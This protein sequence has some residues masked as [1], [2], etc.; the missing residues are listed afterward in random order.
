MLVPAKKVYHATL[1]F[2]SCEAK[3]TG[4]CKS[5]GMTTARVAITIHDGINGHRSIVNEASCDLHTIN[6]VLYYAGRSLS[7]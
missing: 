5:P 6:S 1:K 7:L 2:S 3:H 4:R